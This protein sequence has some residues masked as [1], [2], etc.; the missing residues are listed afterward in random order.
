M[1]VQGRFVRLVVAVKVSVTRPGALDEAAAVGAAEL[2]GPTRGVCCSRPD[3]QAVRRGNGGKAGGRKASLTALRGLVRAVATVFVVV[4][5]E[6]FG[7]A[8]AVLA[9]ELVAAARVVEH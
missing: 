1:R 7:D 2:F 5:H 9:H 3:S 4:A 8:L 6:V